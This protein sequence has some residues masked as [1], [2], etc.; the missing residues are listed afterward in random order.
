MY[1]NSDEEESL[2]DTAT[3]TIASSI[4]NNNNF[5]PV[6]RDTLQPLMMEEYQ[7]DKRI[8]RHSLLKS[9]TFL[10]F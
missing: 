2:V 1:P 5:T 6:T 4:N 7:M 3:T 9:L 10:L 8:E